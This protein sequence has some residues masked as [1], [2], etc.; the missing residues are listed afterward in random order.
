MLDVILGTT[1]AGS[2][3]GHSV[4][5][6][7]PYF[8]ELKNVVVWCRVRIISIVPYNFKLTIAVGP[9]RCF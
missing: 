6:D 5:F 9:T 1:L 2:N 3:L 7:A 8:M 4:T